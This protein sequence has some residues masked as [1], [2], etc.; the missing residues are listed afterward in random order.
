MHPTLSKFYQFWPRFDLFENRKK[1]RPISWRLFVQEIHDFIFDMFNNRL[2]WN[3]WLDRKMK[4]LQENAVYQFSSHWRQR[5]FFVSFCFNSRIFGLVETNSK[6]FVLSFH[7]KIILKFSCCIS[8]TRI[9]YLKKLHV[10]TSNFKESPNETFMKGSLLG[11]TVS[12]DDS[13]RCD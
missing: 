4:L 5:W 11:L 13:A 2:F 8:Y 7:K 1:S 6:V 10:V 12:H 9:N 3:L